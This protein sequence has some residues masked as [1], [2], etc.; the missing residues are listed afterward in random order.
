M[1]N[2]K[3]NHDLYLD[4]QLRPPDPPLHP[5]AQGQASM[6]AAMEPVLT[7]LLGDKPH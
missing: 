2:G 4:P 1:K 3:L 6:S 5:T 7:R